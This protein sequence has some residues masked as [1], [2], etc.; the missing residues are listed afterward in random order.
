MNMQKDRLKNKQRVRTAK[1]RRVSS[2]K[3]LERHINDPY[4]QM[5]REKGYRSRAAF[6][7][8]QINEKYSLLAKQEAV[9]DLGCAPGG[10]L[11]VLRSKLPKS[12]Q[13]VGIDLQETE[14][15]ANTQ[16]IVG[17]F[18]EASTIAQI[19]EL[20]IAQF[21]LVVSDM[22]ASSCGLPEVD[23]LKSM[24]LIE[25]VMMFCLEHLKIDGSMVCKVIRGGQE[26]ELQRKLR[27]I[28]KE[29]KQYKPDASYASSAE[30]YF[31]CKG[32]KANINPFE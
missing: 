4:V 25:A 7:L 17:D 28:F 6:K 27:M 18:F 9:V 20:G 5:S 8:L 15:V 30:F 16:L 21:D 10:W 19:E 14:P 2:T 26:V 1:G 22:A 24:A 13:I 23:H 3:W 11:Q 31:V 12:C 32:F 29:V